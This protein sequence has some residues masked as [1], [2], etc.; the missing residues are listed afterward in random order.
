MRGPDVVTRA[1]MQALIL[2]NQNDPNISK[3]VYIAWT[4][5][6]PKPMDTETLERNLRR[7]GSDLGRDVPPLRT[8][9]RRLTSRRFL[10]QLPGQKEARPLMRPTRTREGWTEV[11]LNSKQGA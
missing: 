7:L 9:T 11:E 10:V 3:P 6:K 2:R 5:N 4:S 1:D 8:W